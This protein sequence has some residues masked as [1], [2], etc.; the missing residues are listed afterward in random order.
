MRVLMINPNVS[1]QMTQKAAEALRAHLPPEATLVVETG[2]F[3]ATV[4]A[5]RAAYTIAGH[6]ALDC[7]ARHA[8]T[9]D[10][11]VLACF[12]DPGLEALREVADVPVVALLEASVRRAGQI[13][14]PFGIITAGAAWRPMLEERIAPMSQAPLFKGIEVLDT[15]GLDVSRDPQAWSVPIDRAK[16]RLLARGAQTII[17][18]GAA[19]AGLASRMGGDGQL[20]DCVIAAA[21]YLANVLKEAPAARPVYLGIQSRGLTAPLKTLLATG[22]R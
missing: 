16:H 7:Y 3:G 9:C 4:I 14:R 11:V 12:G 5:S 19:L 18:G 13:G 2:R 20:I 21:Q 6:A 15:D 22:S 1:L 8:R 10:A 17:L